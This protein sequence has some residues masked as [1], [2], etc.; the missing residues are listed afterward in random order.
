M[1]N[2]TI[3]K[4]EILDSEQLDNVTGGRDIKPEEWHKYIIFFAVEPNQANG[5][6]AANKK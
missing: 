6:L 5:V 2:K 1:A 3:L 4:D